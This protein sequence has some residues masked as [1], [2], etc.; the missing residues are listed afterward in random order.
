[1]VGLLQMITMAYY[2]ALFL[3]N[4][5]KSVRKAGLWIEIQIQNFPNIKE[6]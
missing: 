4:Y 2:K 5:E 3:E 6:C 1:M